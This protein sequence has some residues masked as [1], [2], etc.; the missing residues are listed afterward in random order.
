[1]VATYTLRA[2]ITSRPTF[3][4]SSEA[5][6]GDRLNQPGH[7]IDTSSRASTVLT[8]DNGIGTVN[9][10]ENT[11]FSVQRLA[12]LDDGARITILSV[13]QG[14]ARIQARPFSNPSSLLELHTPSGVAAVRGTEFGVNVA[15][16][17]K[18]SIGTLEGS[19]EVS[20]QDVS[21][22][23]DAGFVSIVVPGEPP[24]PPIPLDQELL[25]DLVDLHRR[26]RNLHLQG[27]I[28]AANT[29]FVNGHEVT[30]GRSGWF[31][32]V[33][34]LSHRPR[35]VTFT[36]RNPLGDERN[37]PIPVWQADIDRD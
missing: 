6:P 31:S 5:Q 9:V 30:I 7:G 26:D 29:L 28:N 20:A 18:S 19:V 14:Q 16:D 15:E 17:G 37:Y 8:I 4:T 2:F 1:L 24:T 36:V 32:T 23:V 35:T 13:T 21:V 34:P 10:A 25:L 11:R 33:I 3:Q 27:R 12:T 22:Q